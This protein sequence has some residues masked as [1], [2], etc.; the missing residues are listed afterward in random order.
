MPIAGIR[1]AGISAMRTFIKVIAEI[2]RA[3]VYDGSQNL[4]MLPCDPVAA[5]FDKIFS[6]STN[7]IAHFKGW[8]F[9]LDARVE[10][11]V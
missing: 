2:S 9:Y 5:V 10:F 8:P 7:N 1:V 11:F 3:A 6:Y 4:Q